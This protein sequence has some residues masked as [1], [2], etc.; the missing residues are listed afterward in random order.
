MI[1]M[2]IQTRSM[3]IVQMIQVTMYLAIMMRTGI[4]MMIRIMMIILLVFSEVADN[5]TSTG[6]KSFVILTPRSTITQLEMS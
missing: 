6:K 4:V 1:R 3:T 5:V 2:S